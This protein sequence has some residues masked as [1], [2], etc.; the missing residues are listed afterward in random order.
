MVDQL[1]QS[2]IEV[3]IIALAV[4]AVVAFLVTTFYH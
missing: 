1:K 3:L 2:A 4:I